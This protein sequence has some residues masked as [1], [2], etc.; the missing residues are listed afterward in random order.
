MSRRRSIV[1]ALPHEVL[2][3]SYIDISDKIFALEQMKKGE[4]DPE[5][6]K[7][8]Q[9]KIDQYTVTYTEAVKPETQIEREKKVNN[10]LTKMSEN[11]PH[12][13]K[14]YIDHFVH[15]KVGDIILTSITEYNT[16]QQYGKK[17]VYGI[18][19]DTEDL[20]MNPEITFIYIE[21]NSQDGYSI[22]QTNHY[23]SP[24][25]IEASTTSQLT[26]YYKEYVS[27]K[28][29]REYL[30]RKRL[31]QLA[32]KYYKKNKKTKAKS[33]GGRKTRRHKIYRFMPSPK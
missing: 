15:P 21:P 1:N 19:V 16:R 2:P 31:A 28:K 13:I 4:K 6:I 17:D 10:A 22:G 11:L 30:K 7:G 20:V 18:V 3:E 12:D 27:T 14:L 32:A 8:I 33:R 9:D 23:E 24:K 5:K 29:H 25:N 26:E